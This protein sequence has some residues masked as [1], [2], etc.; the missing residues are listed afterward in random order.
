MRKQP[1]YST[2]RAIQGANNHGAHAPRQLEPGGT[3][4]GGGFTLIELLV[5]IA[6]IAILAAMLLPALAKAKQ[7][8]LQANCISNF[9]QMGLGLHM[10]TDDNNDWLPPGPGAD[11]I[12]LDQTQGSTYNNTRNSRKW[13]PYYLATYL[14]YPSPASVGTTTQYVARAFIC[15]AYEGSLP[16][17]SEAGYKAFS[18]N[19]ANAFSYSALRNTN[20]VDY[21]ISF[22]PFGKNTENKPPHKITAIP[23]ASGVWAL[24]DFDQQ[25]VTDR[26]SIGGARPYVAVKPV[27]GST[28]NFLYF[29]GRVGSKR[30]KTPQDY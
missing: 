27:H 18:D 13:L 14:S 23:N 9:K 21:Q 8:A 2:E 4:L 24:A 30:V 11:P 25:A 12:G 26:F 22:L 6:I 16:A 28:R 1:S 3:R 29:D 7:K 5:V 15:P 17:N 10:Y 20:A 19:Y